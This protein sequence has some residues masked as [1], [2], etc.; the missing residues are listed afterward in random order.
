MEQRYR[1]VVI[2]DSATYLKILKTYLER[3][4]YDV[5][6]AKTALEGL[7]MVGRT[8][9]HLILC[10]FLLPGMKGDE[11]CKQVKLNH[12][13]RNIP[14]I[15]LTA[16]GEREDITQGLDAGADDYCIKSQDIDLLLIRVRN[17]LRKAE[18]TPNPEEFGRPLLARQKV[19]TIEDDVFYRSMLTKLL[20]EEG[21]EVYGASEG[22]EG[23]KLVAQHKF[24]LILVD[25]IMPGLLGD[26][27]CRVL[28]G[29]EETREIPVVLLTSRGDK[30]DMIAG[31][32]AGADDYIVKS[33][34]L[35][36]L[37][38][39]VKALI[40]RKFYQD[41]HRRIQEELRGHEIAATRAKLER[42]LA[43]EKAKLADALA[44][45]NRVLEATNAKL[46]ETQAALVHAEKM[47]ALGQLVAGIAHEINN[48]LAYVLNNLVTIER[49]AQDLVRG[50]DTY[51]SAVT[52]LPELAAELTEMEE[53][54]EL[55]TAQSELIQYVADSRE[56]LDRMKNIVLNLRNFSRLDEGDSKVVDV[57][58]GI[59]STLKIIAHLM[60]DRIEVE[61]DYG[62]TPKVECFPGL[63]NQVFMN[64][65]VNATQAI[66]TKGKITIRTWTEPEHTVRVAIS[67][68]G[69]GIPP[70]VRQKIF[71]PFF[72]T[73]P[74]GSGTGLGLSTS[75]GIM[76][77]HG[78]QIL[79]DSTPGQGSTFTVVLRSTLTG[80]NTANG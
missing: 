31:L 56:G 77:K 14:V 20:A 71:D 18:P 37:K 27:V 19:L 23:L 60:K 22:E 43:Q 9:P 45:Q 68:T 41:E 80:R 67:D 25:F 36:V 52:R 2:D 55:A 4:G 79:V 72:T 75:Y 59:D 24:D 48:P 54:L 21:Y 7:A 33:T 57:T 46:R 5:R 76:Q 16:H 78:G 3:E 58:E 66:A 17:F 44:A 51:R 26:E 15:M 50:L 70:E 28:K 64:L 74:V 30:T 8:A 34:D 62:Q 1:V 61:R 38:S 35:E 6:T 53:E 40:R 29:Q 63:L 10:D 13:T 49:D 32:N 65:L 73:K 11:F 39:R 69:V 47:G 12:A 42:D